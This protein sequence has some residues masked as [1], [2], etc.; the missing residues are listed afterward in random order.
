[1]SVRWVSSTMIQEYARRNGH[2]GLL[3]EREGYRRPDRALI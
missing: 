2:A 1:M 3:P